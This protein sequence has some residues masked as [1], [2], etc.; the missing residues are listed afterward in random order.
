MSSKKIDVPAPDFIYDPIS[1]KREESEIKLG[2]TEKPKRKR[3]WWKWLL[4]AAGALG[5]AYALMLFL[6]IS[7]ISTNPFGFGKLK[8]EADG[9]VNILVLGIGDP[10]HEGEK[11]ADTTM[12]VSLDTRAGKVA[13]ISIP[14]DTRVKIPG[15]GQLKINNAHAYGDIPLAK[16]VVED[17]LGIPIHYYIRANFSGLKQAVDAVGGIDINVKEAMY[18]P[19]YPC[20]KNEAKMCG[21]KIK[22]GQQHMDGATALKYAR[23]RKGSCGDDFGRAARQ[24]EVLIAIRDK[25]VSAGTLLNPSKLTALSNA[26]GG[27]IKTDLSASNVMRLKDLTAKIDSAQIIKVVFSIKPNGFLEVASDGTS[28]LVPSAGD[29]SDI[30]AFVADVFTKA[31]LWSEEPTITIQNGTTVVGLGGKLQTKL[32]SASPFIQITSLSNAQTHYH[33]TTTLID[34]TGGK[35]PHTLSYLEGLLK[36]KATP[37]ETA[38]KYP[39]ADFTIIIGGDYANYLGSST[40]TSD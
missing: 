1:D 35:K 22:A 29:F 20:D 19:E 8:G 26:L 4:F 33:A 14:R 24:Q 15:Y 21:F 6:N 3:R 39:P 36:V 16:Q 38:T 17:T 10:G 9:R 32:E 27:N 40:S 11:L 23:C 2:Q 13:M 37:P 18:D 30:Q 12:V 34:Y 28:D 31:P 25:A 5:I 7:K